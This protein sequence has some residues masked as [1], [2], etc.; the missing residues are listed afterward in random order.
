MRD[1]L[2]TTLD[3]RDRHE[4]H[5]RFINLCVAGRW[6]AIAIAVRHRTCRYTTTIS[7]SIRGRSASDDDDTQQQPP[8]AALHT[9][10]YVCGVRVC[11]SSI[12]RRGRASAC[13]PCLLEIGRGRS[14]VQGAGGGRVLCGVRAA[15][16]VARWPGGG[17]FFFFRLS[18]L[19]R[20]AF[21]GFCEEWR[22]ER[23][24]AR[25]MRSDTSD[26]SL[27]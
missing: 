21:G 14:A 8:F 16:V 22:V 7:S 6:V 25:Q 2:G 26:E 15:F 20:G 9:R 23:A 11:T 19:G 4:K 24:A 17:F 10:T 1:D 27:R 18:W 3:M 12:V 5:L 13:E